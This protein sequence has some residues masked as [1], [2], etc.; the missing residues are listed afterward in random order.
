MVKIKDIYYK[1]RPRE[2]LIRLGA[3]KLK[4]CELLALILNTGVKNENVINLSKKIL[5]EIS[6]NKL[7][8]VN[9]QQLLKIKGIGLAKVSKIAACLE[10]SK[11]I[12]NNTL[13]KIVYSPRN[14]WEDLKDIR[15]SKKEYFY[16]FCLDARNQIIKKELVSIGILNASIVHP[17][18]V[19]EPAIRNL[20]AQIILSHNHPSQDVS[21]SKEDIVL[22]K[23]LIEISK[24]LGIEIIDHVIVSKE[25]YFSM[26]KQRLL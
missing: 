10:L 16:V 14:I 5:K 15:N 19:F 6:F 8:T 23:R 3:D 7:K 22:T 25:K 17:R 18:E 20:A 21:P 4:D 1:D 9:I 2:R 12:H 24:I 13:N 26:K 11:R